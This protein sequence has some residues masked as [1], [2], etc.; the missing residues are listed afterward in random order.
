METFA[1][2]RARALELLDDHLARARS[3]LLDD[4]PDARVELPFEEST[5]RVVVSMWGNYRP[6]M[7]LQEMYD[8]AAAC[9]FLRSER[10][11]S[12]VLSALYYARVRE[13]Q[14]AI[15]KPKRT[16]WRSGRVMLPSF[17][18]RPAGWCSRPASLPAF[19]ALL[20]GPLEA[21]VEQHRE[22]P[23]SPGAAEALVRTLISRPKASVEIF[24]WLS[25]FFG[26][27]DVD[28]AHVDNW[29][30]VLSMPR[31]RVKPDGACGYEALEKFL[32]FGQSPQPRVK[33]GLDLKT[34][35]LLVRYGADFDVVIDGKKPLERFVERGNEA[36]V[37]LLLPLTRVDWIMCDH[38]ATYEIYA[39][40]RRARIEQQMEFLKVP[41][42][43]RPEILRC[44]YA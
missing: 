35:K 4:A 16:M 34:L 9:M 17:T 6:A 5:V 38:A 44:V 24:A 7:R 12:A 13:S 40:M 31:T 36:A 1:P 21:L 3:C 27:L 18:V 2:I 20:S 25:S 19:E 30:M 37:D 42:Q 33:H 28:D 32:A 43:L 15:E 8:V 41:H 14:C 22:T 23:L 10:E 26:F 29:D 39:K 11:L